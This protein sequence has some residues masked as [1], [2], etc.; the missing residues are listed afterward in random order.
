MAGDTSSTGRVVVCD[1]GTGLVKCGFAG[2]NFPRAVFPCIIGRPVVRYDERT[3]GHHLKDVYVGSECSAHKQQL[4]LS[5]PMKNGIVQSWDDMGRVWDHAFFEQLRIDPRESKIMLTDPALNPVANR[6][7][8]VQVMF[9]KY[10]FSALFMQ[11][12]AVLT[13]YAQGLLTGLVLDSGDGV[14]HAVPVVD[15]YAFHHVMKRLNVAGRH[16]TNYLVELLMRRGY[17]LNRTA[18]FDSV[19]NIKEALSYVACDYAREMKLARETTHLMR[20]YTLPDGRVIRLGPER[21]MAPE[22]MFSPHL[23]DVEAPGIAEMAFNC[24]QDMDID[25]RPL[26]YQH[27]VLSGGST[28]YPGLST[29]MDQDLRQLYLDKILKGN[30]AGLRKLKLKIEDPPNRKHMVFLGGAVLADIM[31]DRHDF[32]ISKQEYEED[33]H[34]AMKKCG[35]L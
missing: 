3:T 20:S 26:L 22:A 25:N 23:V 24:I 4:E 30:K 35:F 8:M 32:W 10:G 15:G 28:M 9:E 29:R 19:R 12:Q 31:K 11:I 5:Y 21:F 6:E 17:A 18:D 33:P 14:S 27:I 7:R 16:V 2:D 13:L 34:R 1:N